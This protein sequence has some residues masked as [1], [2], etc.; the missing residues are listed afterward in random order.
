[1][2]PYICQILKNSLSL[3]LLKTFVYCFTLPSVEARFFKDLSAILIE[4]DI[5]KYEYF[6]IQIK[7]EPNELQKKEASRFTYL[8]GI[9]FGKDRQ[10][11]PFL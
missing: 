10:F 5:K 2:T 8:S 3:P 9:Y 6:K 11:M 7:G 4:N 1:M